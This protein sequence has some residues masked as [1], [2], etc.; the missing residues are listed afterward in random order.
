MSEQPEVEPATAAAEEGAA[1]GSS[2]AAQ[3]AAELATDAAEGGEFCAVIV[4]KTGK[5]KGQT[6][7]TVTMEDVTV[8]GCR[9][10]VDFHFWCRCCKNPKKQFWT[11][12]VMVVKCEP[13]E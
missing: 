9:R 8:G 7:H 13:R 6:L 2:S 3:P 11:S 12:N 5:H 4:P 1:P 10:K